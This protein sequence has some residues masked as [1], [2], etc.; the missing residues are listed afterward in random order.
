M[1]NEKYRV[2]LDDGKYVFT[3]TENYEVQATRHGQPW[4]GPDDSLPLAGKALGCMLA[5]LSDLDKVAVAAVE[6]EFILRDDEGRKAIDNLTV[7]PLRTALMD[8]GIPLEPD[9]DD[10]DGVGW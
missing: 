6:L 7:Q 1:A 9:D 10:E 2:S 3:V 8:A 5:R 4:L